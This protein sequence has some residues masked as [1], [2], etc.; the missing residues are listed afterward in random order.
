MTSQPIHQ[1]AHGGDRL[2]Y[3]TDGVFA[4]VMTLL[5]LE[6]PAPEGDDVGRAI[7]HAL[8]KLAVYLL[9]VAVLGGMWFRNRTESEFIARANHAYS[10]LTFAWLAVVALIPWSA[11]VMMGH[12]RS[13][14]AVA[15]FTINAMLAAAL[16]QGSWWYATGPHGLIDD[17]PVRLLRASRLV[18]W[19]PV[20]DFGL[21]LVVSV[22]SP[23]AALI[24]NLLA[25][26]AYITGVL[27]RLLARL[28]R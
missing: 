5:V 15:T 13:G 1:R 24:L 14:P 2:R 7:V 10:W 25:P 22:V 9:S 26:L 23:I 8:P 11:S 18:G 16:Q 28:S 20:A 27:Y 19:I 3:L 12:P 21:A 4:I 17:L 6:L